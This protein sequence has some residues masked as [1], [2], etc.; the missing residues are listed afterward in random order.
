M[1]SKQNNLQKGYFSEEDWRL[2][3]RLVQEL[4]CDEC[5]DFAISIEQLLG[6]GNVSEV[7]RLWFKEYYE[8]QQTW[9][10]D[11]LT[12]MTEAL[13]RRIRRWRVGEG[14]PTTY[15]ELETF[16]DTM[17]IFIREKSSG[18]KSLDRYERAIFLKNYLCR[19]IY[20]LFDKRGL[21]DGL[22]DKLE[23]DDE[24]WW[25]FGEDDADVDRP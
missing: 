11:E 3:Q 18:A 24:I 5:E 2:I 21:S 16:L 4:Q 13:G 25:R 7:A 15:G 8:D 12:K 14:V 10:E 19:L 1:Q 23:L 20:G 9:A 22:Q 17:T 6:D